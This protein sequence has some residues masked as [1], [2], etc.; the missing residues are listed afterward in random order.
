MIELCSPALHMTLDNAGNLTFFGIPD[1]E[2]RLKTPISFVTLDTG[3]DS[4]TPVSLSDSE[5]YLCFRFADG[6]L[7]YLLPAVA[8]CGISLDTAGFF[9]AE[10]LTDALCDDLSGCS[11]R[12]GLASTLPGAVGADVTGAAPAL[13][14]SALP[15]DG[16]MGTKLAL[17]ICDDADSSS[18]V[19]G[20]I[21]NFA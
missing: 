20:L 19:T 14:A 1:G 18:V 12:F 4:M 6:S 3:H 16:F 11:I 10:S 15:E 8:D 17:T 2:N 5:G 21:W 7:F 9:P 13:Y